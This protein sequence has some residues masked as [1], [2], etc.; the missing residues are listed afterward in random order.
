M[1]KTLSMGAFT[2]LDERE[3]M[4]TEGGGIGVIIFVAACAYAIVDLPCQGV[5]YCNKK[6]AQT[7]ANASNE[8]FS[9][10]L[11]GP[12]EYIRAYAGGW[13]PTDSEPLPQYTAYPQ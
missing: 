13:R 3:V 2:E 11:I 9:V 12:T 6:T 8:P 1:E 5:N 10:D 4:E 7:N